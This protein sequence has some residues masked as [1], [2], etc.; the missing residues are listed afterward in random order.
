MR[1]IITTILLAALGYAGYWHVGARAL[2]TGTAEFIAEMPTLEVDGHHVNGFPYRFQLRLEGPRLLDRAGRTVWQVSEL[3][4]HAL[5]Y[6]PHHAIAVFPEQQTLQLGLTPALLTSPDA[7]ASI[8]SRAAQ[9]PLDLARANL[10][11]DQ[12]SLQ[13][14][15]HQHRADSLRAAL[16]HLEKASYGFALELHGLQPDPGLLRLLDPQQSLPPMI[17]RMGIRGELGL[18]HPVSLAQPENTLRRIGLEEITLDWG[19]LQLEGTGQLQLAPTGT[20]DGAVTLTISGWEGALELLAATGNFAPDA[21]QMIAA[22]LNG[23]TDPATGALNVTLT[24][25]ESLVFLGPLV[26]G[27]LPRL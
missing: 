11:L 24:L 6:R 17:A 2:D 10:V 4:I 7:R 20:L 3:D 9:G 23:M 25:R 27:Q 13:I 21:V 5:S 16:R 22:M 8:V 18:D 15:A 12:P 19:D 26:L 1:L 14:D